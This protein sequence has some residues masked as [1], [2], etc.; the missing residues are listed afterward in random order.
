MIKN[1]LQAEFLDWFNNYLTI[2]KFAEHRQI[3]QKQAKTLIKLGRE[4]HE[5]I[6]K[7]TKEIQSLKN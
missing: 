2:K 7:E 1:L 4:I 3:T 6:V 5:Q